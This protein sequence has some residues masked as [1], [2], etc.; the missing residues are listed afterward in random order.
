MLFAQND[1]SKR[2]TL[3]GMDVKRLTMTFNFIVF[4]H[5]PIMTVDVVGLF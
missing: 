4:D 1:R 2:L 3:P 5:N